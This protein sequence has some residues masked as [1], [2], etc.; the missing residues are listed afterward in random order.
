MNI[1]IHT[2]IF[3]SMEEFELLSKAS[4]LINEAYM[5]IPVGAPEV[6]VAQT[7][8]TAID[9]F[10]KICEIEEVAYENEDAV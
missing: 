10:I 9:D 2:R 3:L 8:D 5:D 7:A 1:Q 6:T 4:A